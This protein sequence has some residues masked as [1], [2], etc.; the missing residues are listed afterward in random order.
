MEIDAVAPPPHPSMRS[1]ASDTDAKPLWSKPCRACPLRAEIFEARHQAGYWRDRHQRA[2]EREEK[3]R[4]ENEQLRAKNKELERQ[5]FGRRSEKGHG[6]SPETTG[7]STQ[8]RRRRGQQ[9]GRPGPGRRNTSHL[10]VE[11][12]DHALAEDQCYCDRCGLPF[13]DFPGTEDSEVLEIEIRGYKRRI[14]RRRYRPTCQC[15]HL[16]GIITAPG[17]AKL[18]PKGRLGVSLWVEILLDKYAFVRPTQR[19]L[20]DLRSHGIDLSLGTVTGG[21]QQLAPVFKP[22]RE[23]IIRMNLEQL[24]WHADETRW[25]VFVPVEGKVGWQWKFWVFQSCSAVVFVLDATREARVPETYY[26]G[27]E[28]G[29]LVVDRYSGYKAMAQVKAGQILLAFCWAHVRRDFLGVAR[30]WAGHKTWGLLWLD[31]IN[32]LFHL[33]NLR[34]EA[35]SQQ[36]AKRDEILRAEVE[37]L[38]ERRQEELSDPQLHPVRRKPLVSLGNHWHGLTLFVDHPEI[39]MDN[40]TAERTLRLL[41]CGR[42][43]FFGSRAV[44]AGNLAADLFHCSRRFSCG[45]S[46]PESGCMPICMPAHKLAA[47]LLPTPPAGCPGICHRLNARRWPSYRESTTRPEPDDAL[48]W[49]RVHRRRLGPDPAAHR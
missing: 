34:L 35:P 16:P 29:T 38:A 23:E 21:L 3:L 40:N 5:L 25:P 42:K 17:P 13:E 9:P 48:L 28:H 22:I 30:D 11:E 4:D 15:E 10:P 47:K 31:R 44:W 39:P 7:S 8:R 45:R 19:L 36:F 41:V 24:V 26:E 20:S 14:R 37:K 49:P 33:N 1:P 18:I 12:E 6:A 2:Q 43:Q 46:I 32:E 27:I